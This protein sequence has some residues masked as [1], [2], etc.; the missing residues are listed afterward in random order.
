MNYWDF[1]IN[2]WIIWKLIVW[3]FW[4]YVR[5]NT[6]YYPILFK[7]WFCRSSCISLMQKYHFCVAMTSVL[8][9]ATSS[10]TLFSIYLGAFYKLTIEILKK[11]C[12][13]KTGRNAAKNFDYENGLDGRRNDQTSRAGPQNSGPLTTLGCFIILVLK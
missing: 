9:L 7:T 5:H 6:N 12:V 10:P 11:F 4:K 3:G 1:L 8:K 13:F 2:F